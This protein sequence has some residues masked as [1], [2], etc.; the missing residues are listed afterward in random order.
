MLKFYCVQKQHINRYSTCDGLGIEIRSVKEQVRK[1]R[2]TFQYSITYNLSVSLLT[3]QKIHG[4]SRIRK[5][6]HTFSFDQLKDLFHKKIKQYTNWKF[7]L[8]VLHV[9]QTVQHYFKPN[10]SCTWNLSYLMTYCTVF[11]PIMDYFQFHLTFG[12]F[13]S[14]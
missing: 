6:R 10:N 4:A 14:T 8:L 13:I 9:S 7:N 11:I 3:F 2:K 5:E 12:I 1:E